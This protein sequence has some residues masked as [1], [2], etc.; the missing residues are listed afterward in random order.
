MLYFNSNCLIKLDN[1]ECNYVSC[2]I[3]WQISSD[4]FIIHYY[5]LLICFI[6]FS[7]FNGEYTFEDRLYCDKLVDCFRMHVDYGFV[8]M[9]FWDENKD[10]GKPD[11]L[12]WYNLIYILVVNLIL[13]AI[14]SGIIIDTFA[15]RKGWGYS[16]RW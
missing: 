5:C 15:G 1:E 12:L 16:W 14:I 4:C 11:G 7:S 10:G 3:D 8:A 6:F 13:T 2:F 9:P